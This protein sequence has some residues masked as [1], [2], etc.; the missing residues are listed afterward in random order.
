[1]LPLLVG[2]TVLLTAADHWTTYLC[3]RS[4][5]SGWEVTEANPLAD[6]L[7]GSLGLVEGLLVDSA[8][9]ALAIVFLIGTRLVPASAK[10]FFFGFVA[11]WTAM[12]VFNNLQAMSVLGLSP[13]G[14]A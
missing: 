7:F 5:V 2:M 10:L 13:W 14:G 11:L 6:W 4:P 8:V 9:S 3:L 1:M 12:A